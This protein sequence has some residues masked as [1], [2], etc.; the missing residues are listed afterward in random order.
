MTARARI[1]ARRVA[2]LAIWILPSAVLLGLAAWIHDSFRIDVP[3]RLGPEARAQ[4]VA[5]LRAALLGQPA[6]AADLGQRLP[7]A[8]A[9]RGPVLVSV[10]HEGRIQARVMGHGSTLAVAVRAAADAL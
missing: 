7:Q 9:H 1:G 8:L 2:L 5:E 10:L 6:V 4:V 3:P